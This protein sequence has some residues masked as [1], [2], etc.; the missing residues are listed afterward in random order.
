MK[1]LFVFHSPPGP[2]GYLPD[3]TWTLRYELVGE[4][5]ATEYEARMAAGWRKFGR[6]LF[7]PECPNCTDCQPLRI[8]PNR[9]VPGKTMK[10]V[11]KLNS[12]ALTLTIAEPSVTAEK[13]ELHDRF[14]RFQSDSKGWPFH[15]EKSA[16]DYSDSF[17]DN[18]FPV[19][20]WRYELDGRLAGIG[21]VDAL[22]ASLSMIYFFYDPELRDRSLGTFN[23]LKGLDEAKR[24]KLGHV[25]LGYFVDGCRSLEYKA[26]FGPNEVYHWETKRWIARESSE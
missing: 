7:R 4:L 6:S 1:S 10:R 20:E 15:G 25:Y 21:Y 12:G 13:L 14:H 8:D 3:R 9:F 11:K 2:C 24:R 16:S 17:V 18:P 19:E 26:R 23:V 5:T 22:P